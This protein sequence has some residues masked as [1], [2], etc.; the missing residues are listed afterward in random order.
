MKNQS[1]EN[2]FQSNSIISKCIFLKYCCHLITT[3]ATSTT[4]AATTTTITAKKCTPH[5]FY[6][7][8][9]EVLLSLHNNNIIIINNS[10]KVHTSS[11]CT[12]KNFF[13]PYSIKPFW[14]FSEDFLWT[15]LLTNLNMIWSG[16]ITFFRVYV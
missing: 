11:F 8:C 10:N 15:L 2:T 7:C 9:F 16:K 13:L 5:F 3:G 1:S 12:A 6:C 4:T 14:R